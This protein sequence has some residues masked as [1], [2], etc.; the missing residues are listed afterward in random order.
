MK[1]KT[2]LLLALLVSFSLTVTPS[3][4]QSAEMAAK[5]VNRISENV[6]LDKEQQDKLVEMTSE[7]EIAKYQNVEEYEEA[8]IQ[9]NNRIMEYLR[10][11]QRPQFKEMLD[12]DAK[13]AAAAAVQRKKEAAE[14]EKAKNNK[15]AEPTKAKPATKP[16]TKPVAKPATKPGTTTTPKK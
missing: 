3:S 6:K 15:A 11:D 14:R 7:V 4:G 13:A 5:Y 9:L 10:A 16:A 2:S 8:K 12:A 1:I